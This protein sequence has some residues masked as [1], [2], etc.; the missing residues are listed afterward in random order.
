MKYTFIV[1]KTNTGYSAYSENGNDFVAT[2]GSS[3]P[4]LRQNII[5]AI[6]TYRENEGL[7]SITEKD[8][9]VKLDIPQFFEYYNV[10]NST[11]LAERIGV[12][13]SL[14]SQYANGIK[15]PSTKQVNKILEGV[16]SLGKELSQIELV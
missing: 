6:N 11:A 4:E 10:I 16:R 2:A 3:M 13:R 8:L 15:K 7:K 5:D 1:E 9:I 12:S 14:L